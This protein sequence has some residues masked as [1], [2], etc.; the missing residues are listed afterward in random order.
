MI[1]LTP[2]QSPLESSWDI[3]CPSQCLHDIEV[4]GSSGQGKC[5]CAVREGDLESLIS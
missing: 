1:L 2:T 5:L 3:S 4:D